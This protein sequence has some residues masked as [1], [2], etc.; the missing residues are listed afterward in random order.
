M[1]TNCRY[2]NGYKP[3]GKSEV[4]S[5]DCPHRDIP[6]VSV[7]IIHLGALGAV[8]RAT[9]LLPAIKRKY[10]SSRITWVTDSPAHHLL[11][12]NPYLDRILTSKE[13]DL[14]VLSNLEFDVAY[15]VDKSLKAS[16]IL[17]RTHADLVFGFKVDAR[18]GAIIPANPEADELWQL[19][20][21]NHRKFY[22]NKKPETQLMCEALGLEYRRDSYVLNLTEDEQKA[23]RKKRKVWSQSLQAPIIGINTGCSHV[24]PYK[25]LTVEAHIELIQKLQWNT[26]ANIVL[27]GGPE[28]TE[29][30]Q[31]IGN[32]TKSIVSPTTLGLREG[33]TSVGAVDLVITGDSLGMHMAIALKKYTIAWFGPT[34]SHEIDLYGHGEAILSSASCSPCWKRS[35]NKDIMCYDLLDLERIVETTLQFLCLPNESTLVQI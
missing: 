28:D 14:L 11:A 10:P 15:V 21:D 12:Q 2:F 16:G 7:L 1:E 20:L 32:A 29:R 33:L 3:C 6:Q 13:E 4:C 34:C 24:I 35:C 18:S 8:L 5:S 30:N 9:S 23:V 25:K 31:E 26:R 22:V 19:G 17:K 27:L